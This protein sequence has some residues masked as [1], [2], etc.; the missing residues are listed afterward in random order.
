ML[1]AD[2]TPDPEPSV[3][4]ARRSKCES[5]TLLITSSSLS[6]TAAL[7]LA[8]SSPRLRAVAGFGGR[9]PNA[10]PGPQAA[11]KERLQ[12]ERQQDVV[13][14]LLPAGVACVGRPVLA[15][16][17]GRRRRS[18]RLHGARR[19]QDRGRLHGDPQ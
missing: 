9:A 3:G 5:S 16:R 4:G 19:G 7:N 1:V 13:R 15:A 18:R 2:A 12:E 11:P 8:I 14:P 10:S 6:S 17:S